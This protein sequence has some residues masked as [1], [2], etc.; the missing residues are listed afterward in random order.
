MSFNQYF[1]DFTNY[2]NA[3]LHQHL[4]EGEAAHPGLAVSV[5][6]WR[7]QRTYIK[8]ALEVRG[9]PAAG[10]TPPTFVSCQLTVTEEEMEKES[11]MV[12]WVAGEAAGL[13]AAATCC[14]LDSGCSSTSHIPET[15]LPC[16]AGPHSQ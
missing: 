5:E 3:W 6:S 10:P 15:V 14:V 4:A 11:A 1:G 13:P 12:L 7:R 2:T 16:A 9:G 8:W